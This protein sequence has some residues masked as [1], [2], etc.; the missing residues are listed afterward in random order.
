METS[1]GLFLM[2]LGLLIMVLDCI[3]SASRGPAS[4]LGL[5]VLLV[6]GFI[7]PSR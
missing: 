5:A 2:G 4:L 3:A 7:Y 6:G 1:A